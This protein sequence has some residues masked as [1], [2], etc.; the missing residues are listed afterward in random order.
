MRL[1]GLFELLEGSPGYRSLLERLAQGQFPLEVA[2]AG[3]ARPYL[4]G[5]LWSRLGRPVLVVTPRPEDARRL[6]DF[7]TTYLGE[8]APAYLLPEPEVLPY[9]RL[10]ADAVTL[11]QRLQVL[12]VLSGVQGTERPPLIVTSVAGLLWRTPSPRA[13]RQASQTLKVGQGLA[14][15]RFTSRLLEL[16]YRNEEGVEVPG[17]FARRGG[18]LDLFPPTSPMPV[19][20]EMWGDDIEGIRLFDPATQRSVQDVQSVTVVPAREALPALADQIVVSDLIGRLDLSRCTPAVRDRIQEEMVSLFTSPD[21]DGAENALF[22]NGL[23]NHHS[24]L[25]YLPERALVVLERASEVEAEAEKLEG[26]SE[27][28]RRAREARGELPG[29]FPPAQWRWAELAA[30]LAVRPR[31]HLNAWQGPKDSLAFRPAPSFNGRADLFPQ[32]ARGMVGRSYRLV[33]VTRHSRRMQELLSEADVGATLVP[34][35]EVAPPQGSVTLVQ[36]SLGEGFSLDL[37]GTGLVLFTDSE[38]FGVSKERRYRPRA[39]VRRAPFLS[40]LE[41]GMY[42]VHVDHGVARFAGTTHLDT[43]HGQREYLVLEY[44]EGDKLYVPT[45]QLDRVSQYVAAGDQPPNLTRLGTQDWARAKE[46]VKRSAKEMAQELLKL[47]SARQLAKGHAFSADTPWQRE[48]EDSF[49]YEETPDQARTIQE[50]KADMELERPMDRLVCGDV[51]YGKTEVALRAAFKAVGDGM[52]VAVLVPTTVLAQQHYVTF[53][54]RLAPYPVRVE[55]LSRFRSRKEQQAVVEGLKEGTV[56]I[57]IGTHRVIQKDVAFKN[58]GLVIVD[59]EQR[60]G[61]A[62]K[63]R[64]KQLRTEVDVLSLSATPIPRT[65]YMALSGI[66][67]M[68]TMETPPEERVPVKTYVGEFSDDLVR[69]AILREMERGGQVFYLHN[70]V[71]TIHRAAQKV[72]EL[73]PQARIAVGH[74]QMPEDELEEVMLAFVRGEVDVLVCTTIIESGLDIPNAN[75]LIIDRADMLGLSQLYQLRGRV[76]RGAH[77]A[78]A[79]LLVPRGRRITQTAE[80]RLQAILEASELG[81]GFRIAMRD[82][83]IRGAGNLLGPQQSGHIHA[84]GFELYTQLLQEAVAELQAQQEGAPLEVGPEVQPRIDVGLSAYIPEEYIQHL[85]TRLAIYQRLAKVKERQEVQE[86]AQEL[87]DRFGPVPQP[88]E[89]LLYAAQVRVLAQKARVESVVRSDGQVTLTLVEPVGGAALPLE[90]TLGPG[91][92]VGHQQIRLY[93]G[94]RGD[95]RQ[96]LVKALERLLWFQERLKAMVPAVNR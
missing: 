45:D 44:A 62:H 31:L 86:M 28:M 89:E 57:V 51:G 75:T 15:A 38:L 77:R 11:N 88:V 94:A 76:G 35:V 91:A 83:E 72:Q 7:L 34:S 59:E 12:A 3:G 9:E 65:L 20:I 24:L 84:V 73:V 16:G 90:R 56:D 19:R 43:D 60:F 30:R 1:T 96:G 13:F 92:R 71:K 49:P 67:D 32:Q 6:Y 85:P 48:V 5:A 17:T 53:S 21:M 39:A 64:L 74:G 18:I 82:L 79:Y 55:V 54:E 37:D 69:E 78:Y 61:V 87:R 23:L 81:A 29:R 36:G 25:D 10:A 27:E 42:V 68:S 52:Q 33:V 8:G 95:W 4:L 14:L 66:R 80:K 70:R 22:Y 40:Q 50:V 46:R 58:L 63:E 47:Y 26:Q 93:L 41:P 2:A